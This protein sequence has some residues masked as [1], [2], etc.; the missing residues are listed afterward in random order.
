MKLSLQHKQLATKA[1]KPKRILLA[2]LSPRSLAYTRLDFE[3]SRL[4]LNSIILLSGRNRLTEEHGECSDQNN[5]V[6]D[7]VTI[8]T[9]EK[10]VTITKEVL[11]FSLP[12]E[13]NLRIFY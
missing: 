9:K 10:E 5:L 3:A 6:L 8:T 11:C 13:Q 12:Q 1:F 7:R 4:L 2:L